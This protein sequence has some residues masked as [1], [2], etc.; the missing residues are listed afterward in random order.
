MSS[1]LD[2]M[3]DDDSQ[4]LKEA[5]EQIKSL[6]CQL[7]AANERNVD[8][9]LENNRLSAENAT[10]KI[11]LEAWEVT[12]CG[13]AKQESLRAN[14]HAH[15][16]FLS[17][18]QCSPPAVLAS[19]IPHPWSNPLSIVVLPPPNSGTLL[20]GGADGIVRSYVWSMWDE[21]GDASATPVPSKCMQLMCEFSSPVIKLAT[22]Q[23]GIV[24]VGT[25]DGKV[26]LTTLVSSSPLSR[27]PP[28][29]PSVVHKHKKYVTSLAFSHSGLKLASACASGMIHVS[30]ISDDVST[31][32]SSS[33]QVTPLLS[34]PHQAAITALTFQPKTSALVY[35]IADSA[36]IIVHSLPTSTSQTSDISTI[37]LNGD[38]AWDTHS[39]FSILSISAHPDPE[40][41]Y[42]VLATTTSR[43]IVMDWEGNQLKNYYGAS[44][45]AY[46]TAS[47]SFTS[48]GSHIVASSD[49]G[50][51]IIDELRSDDRTKLKAHTSK[52]RS[53]YVDRH[54]NTVASVGF[55]KKIKVFVT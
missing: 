46:S 25:M 15:N 55:D 27:S 35:H 49:T 43:S 32:T 17:I 18:A 2:M 11:R 44:S 54:T 34:L 21:S 53:F 19:V 50:E 29:V 1:L 13:E 52:V 33:F 26:H 8:L 47:A 48:C 5:H 41:P 45:D 14:S 23:S 36:N 38:R 6:S 51:L 9:K 31:S 24:A 22:E 10:L 3:Q 16:P 30:S 39:S 42:L 4:R 20:T 7:R 28:P 37:T 40:K 12:D